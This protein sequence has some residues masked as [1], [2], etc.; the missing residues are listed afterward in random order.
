MGYRV[1]GVPLRRVNQA[2]VIA[3][4]TK[5]GV[6]GLKG[7]DKIDDTFFAR[8]ENDAWLKVSKERDAKQKELD[9]ALEAQAKKDVTLRKY[10]KARF[11]LKWHVAARAQVLGRSRDF[12]RSQ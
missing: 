3:T 2:Y 8:K 12:G 1:N 10:M 11:S 6:Q 4:S 7:I 5:F 9:S